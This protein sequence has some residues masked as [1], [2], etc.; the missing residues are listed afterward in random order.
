MFSGVADIHE[1]INNLP[2]ILVV[3]R[4]MYIVSLY[5]LVPL[6]R[7]YLTMTINYDVALLCVQLWT[8]CYPKTMIYCRRI[9]HSFIGR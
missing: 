5:A 1:D 6:V 7:L 4:L 3:V 2:F 9:T 8:S